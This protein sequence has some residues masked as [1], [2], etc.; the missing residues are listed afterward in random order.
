MKMRQPLS[1]GIAIAL[2]V[3]VIWLGRSQPSESQPV[4]VEPPVQAPLSSTTPRI[5]KFTVSL[6]SP[7]DLRVRQ[8]DVVA[9][10][11]AL[12]ERVQERSRLEAQRQ[13]ALLSLERIRSAA[14]VSPPPALPVPP[15]APLPPV[16]Y[17]KEAAAIEE[18][19][20]AVDLQLRRM[21]LLSTLPP[22]QV[23]PAMVAHEQQQLAQLQRDLDAA[24]AALQAAQDQRAYD[25]YLHSL[26]MARRAD[27]QN[28]Q[29]LS[30]SAQVQAAAQAQRDRE[31]QIAQLEAQIQ[32]LD[33]QLANLSTVRSPYA[34]TIRRIKWLGQTDN[35]LSVEI[36]LAVGDPPDAPSA[37]FTTLDPEPSRPGPE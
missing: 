33:T 8:G 31:F 27:E 25:E 20:A 34:G 23:P 13:R 12:A 7:D 14:V 28:Q 15:V 4:P 10:G 17:A 9:A 16:S 5:L 11:D 6:Q 21:D 18:A 30:R 19:Q 3:A 22:E 24:Q 2:G 37:P 35:T 1:Y 32:T 29:A 26:Q 36:T